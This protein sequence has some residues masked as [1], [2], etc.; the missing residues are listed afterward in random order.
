M[1]SLLKRHRIL[2]VFTLVCVVMVLIAWILRADVDS[3]A[4]AA[5]AS[6]VAT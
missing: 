3:P 1:W 5:T 6:A 4:V 2:V